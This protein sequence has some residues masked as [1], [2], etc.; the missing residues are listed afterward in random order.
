VG[1]APEIK[2]DDLFTEL[3]TSIDRKYGGSENAIQDLG[4]WAV[5]NEIILDGKKF[6]F[7]N[8]EYLIEPYSDKHPYQVELKATQLGLTSK[9]MLRVFHTSRY[10]GDKYRGIGYYFP[11]RTDVTDLS[12]TRIDPLI[13]D[14]PENIGQWMKDTNAANVKK[15][16]NS[17]LYLRGMRSTIGLKSIPIDFLI[18]DELDEA[19]PKS[20]DMIL[21]R[22]AHSE[23]GELL[24]LSNPTLPDYGIDKL[25]QNSD[26]M[27]WMLKC[28]KCN[29]YTNLVETFPEC[30]LMKKGGEVIRA[31]EKCQAELDP[32]KGEWIAKRPSIKDIRGRQFSQLYSQTKM[33]EP[34]RIL[35][36]FHTT[37]NLTD[38]YNLKIGIAYVEAQNRLSVQQVLDCCGDKG[39]ASSSDAGTFMGVD[40][41]NNLHVVIGKHHPKRAG[42]VIHIGEYIGN[43]EKDG[44]GWKQLDELMTRFKVMRCVVDG[45]PETKHAREFAERFNGRVFLIF[46]N[47]FQKGSYR[48]DEKTRMVTA[49]ITETLD[50]SHRLI[51][52]CDIVLPSKSSDTV[53]EFARHCNRVAKRLEEDEDTHS[54][55]YVYYR[56]LGGPDHWR[57]AFNYFAMSL[58]DSPEL[59]FAELL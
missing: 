46:S 54:Q 49:N 56:K 42:E 19:P 17:N 9:A 59:M 47:V 21:E 27:Y 4:E 26:Q 45:L 24:F 44:S 10:G 18:F 13:D 43:K 38:F 33:T 52:D 30:L 50:A 34:G 16:W 36:T 8:H 6:T 55:R 7:K 37:T 3:I 14:N 11:S 39:I 12:K 40:Q 5:R 32:S 57:M 1:I 25:F 23:V 22:M 35:D 58:T 15:I 51:A 48:W 29:H 31:C 20:V 41:G 28:K 53:Q 2:S